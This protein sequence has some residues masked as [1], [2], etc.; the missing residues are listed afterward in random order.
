MNHI[1]D[2]TPSKQ[3]TTFVAPSKIHAI[4]AQKLLV[5]ETCA[6]VTRSPMSSV[7]L[8]EITAKGPS[9]PHHPLHR[10]GKKEV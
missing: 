10:F 9:D 1:C 5:P 6:A 4:K 3:K 2:T 8:M 7:G